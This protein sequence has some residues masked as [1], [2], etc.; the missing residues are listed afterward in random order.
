VVADS[1]VSK[2]AARVNLLLEVLRD[3][4]SD[5]GGLEGVLGV[6]A[7]DVLVEASVAKIKVV[8]VLAVQELGGRELCRGGKKRQRSD[9]LFHE[10]AVG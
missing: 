5:D 3:L 9:K 1:V 7:M 6:V 8:A 10:R 2:V 4:S